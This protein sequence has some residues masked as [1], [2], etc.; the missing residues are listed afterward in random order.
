[1][2]AKRSRQVCEPALLLHQPVASAVTFVLTS[3]TVSANAAMSPFRFFNVTSVVMEILS[4]GDPAQQHISRPSRKQVLECRF[5]PVWS[6]ILEASELLHRTSKMQPRLVR[7]RKAGTLVCEHCGVKRFP[8][9]QHVRICGLEQ[10]TSARRLAQA[11]QRLG[12]ME[13]F[14]HRLKSSAGGVPVRTGTLS[15]K[16]NHHAVLLATVTEAMMRM[17]ALVTRLQ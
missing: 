8:L 6:N 7:P 9:T 5:G 17:E 11:A 4:C 2:H 12:W 13:R 3:R 15:F 16:L 1:M 14:C 10:E